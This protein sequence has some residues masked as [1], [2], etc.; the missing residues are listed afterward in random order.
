[1]ITERNLF[2]PCNDLN[3]GLKVWQKTARVGGLQC[4]LDWSF[5]H[6]YFIKFLVTT[7]WHQRI[8]MKAYY[9][10]QH[11]TWGETIK[12]F[13]LSTNRDLSI[14]RWTMLKNKPKFSNKRLISKPNL[15]ITR[16]SLT[17]HFYRNSIFLSYAWYW[18]RPHPRLTRPRG[19]TFR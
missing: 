7:F 1:M 16:H 8:D 6:R 11:T 15:L 5:T 18:T 19:E 3:N 9:G 17:A 10:K 4:H 14:K 13:I 12:T 2:L